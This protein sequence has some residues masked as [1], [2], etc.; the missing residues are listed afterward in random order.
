MRF[1]IS[2]TLL[3]SFITM[4]VSLS[5]AEEIKPIAFD[6]KKQSTEFWNSVLAGETYEVCRNAGTEPPG[7]GKLNNFYDE[8]IYYCSC[9]GG[10]FPLY[11]SNTKF[12]SKK[13]WPS[14]SASLPGAVIERPDP[15]DQIKGLV[16]MGKTE[17]LCSRCESHLGHVFN[18]GPKPT[19]KRYSINSAA[20]TFVPK[21]Q[22]PKRSY[23]IIRK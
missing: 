21:G 4:N 18:D 16:G 3:I 9:C 12:D 13:G 22:Q 5:T 7:S 11:T 8:G 10:D 14:F 1:K 6:Y 19:G 15:T 17:I 23:E 2:T 20:L